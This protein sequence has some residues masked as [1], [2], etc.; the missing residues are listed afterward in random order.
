MKT[1]I[2]FVQIDVHRRP[3]GTR[4]GMFGGELFWLALRTRRRRVRL[5]RERMSSVRRGIESRRRRERDLHARRRQFD[6]QI[7]P[8]HLRDVGN[9]FRTI[10][11]QIGGRVYARVRRLVRGR[12]PCCEV[13]LDGTTRIVLNQ[14]SND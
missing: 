2:R 13:Q 3:G 6:A 8:T 7:F 14:H 12:P 9:R 4:L 5:R 1:L 11:T 10:E